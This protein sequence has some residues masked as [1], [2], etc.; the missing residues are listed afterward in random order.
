MGDSLLQFSFL[1][2]PNPLE[3][4]PLSP[5]LA[6]D[7]SYRAATNLGTVHYQPFALSLGRVSPRLDKGF[8]KARAGKREDTLIA[9]IKRYII[10]N[11]RRSRE[12]T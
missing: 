10:N 7:V 5:H 3:P 9:T 11:E 2:I 1:L 12:A 6:G 4:L 8:A